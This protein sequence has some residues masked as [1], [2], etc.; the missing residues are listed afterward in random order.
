MCLHST[1]VPLIT[2]K[3]GSKQPL[4]KSEQTQYD[5]YLEYWSQE[6]GDSRKNKHQ[7]ACYSLF[8]VNWTTERNT[9]E[10]KRLYK[11]FPVHS[12]LTSSVFLS[13]CDIASGRLRRSFKLQP[14]F[15][16]YFY[17]IHLTP[18]NWGCS[19]GALDS[20]SI[21]RESMWAME[22]T[23][24]ATYQGRPMKEQAAIR[25]PTQSRSRW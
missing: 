25:T 13:F 23:V 17:F 7:N 1:C 24:A 14:I 11:P 3:H 19:P 10:K 8:S 2:S 12:S 5:S 22:M 9:L 20:L 16:F 15:S 21:F 4:K 6:D 18:R